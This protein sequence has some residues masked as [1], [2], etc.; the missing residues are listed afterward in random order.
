MFVRSSSG[1]TG[2]RAE[3]LQALLQTMEQKRSTLEDLLG[4][5]SKLS[6]HLSDAQSSGAL[7]AQLGD[8]QED[9]RLLKGGTRRALQQASS[10][11]AQYFL[12]LKEAKQLRDKLEDFLESESD[13]LSSLELVCLSTDLKLYKQLFSALRSQA[14]ALV[15]FSLGQK[16][17]DELEHSLQ[18]LGSLF[19]LCKKKLDD[20]TESCGSSSVNK[21]S[22]QLRDLIIWAKQAEIHISTGQKLALFPEEA[23]AQIDEMRTFQ[24]DILSRRR[25]MR[26]QLEEMKGGAAN[27]ENEDGEVLKTVE[28]LYETITDSLEQVLDSMQTSLDDRLELL[29]QFAS[30]DAWLAETHANREPCTHVEN[31]STALTCHLE[32]ELKTHSLASVQIE[33]Q[34]K[35]LEALS[36]SC[37]KMCTEL[38]PGESRYLV[39]RLSGLWTE[40]EGLLAHEDASSRELEQL[41]RERSSSDQ[42]LASIQES[43]KDVSAD[44]EQQKFP[45]T[46]ETLTLIGNIKHKLMEHQCRVQ[47]LQHCPEGKRH[48]LL[49]SI[50]DLQ[51]RSKA[52]SENAFK[53]D[54]Y[55]FLRGQME[56]SINTVRRQIQDVENPA[57]NLDHRLGLCH[58]VLAEL[59]LMET[60]CKDVADQ[61][62]T[63]AAELQPSEL[64]SEREKIHHA[65]QTLASWERS[66]TLDIKHLEA[67][68]LQRLHFNCELP[69]FTHLLQKTKERLEAAKPVRPDEAA[70]DVVLQQYWV[71][72]RRLESGMR[73]LEALAEREHVDMQN[74]K[75]LYSLRDAALQLG[76]SLL[77]R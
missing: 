50:A 61:L 57:V 46:L 65:V 31:A 56:V 28:D 48:S 59:P 75:H 23:Q 38:S 15:S 22:K 66:V 26:L 9:W 27:V 74:Y 63:V 30:L 44:L 71:D 16:E 45:L 17:K 2:L 69:A 58:A 19:H 68:F 5:S 37:T 8:L 20:W 64:H 35:K 32:S 55:L 76:D 12:L 25:K 77:V 39:T 53:Q 51:D 41:I 60:R 73:V 3:K 11:T 72:H 36:E 7:L 49:C 34:L 52:L 1:G 24:A 10:S 14:D 42:Q 70:I 4:L 13:V 43:L 62:E 6:A 29:G 33:K 47:Q 18:E 21:I 67:Q 54:R 40:L